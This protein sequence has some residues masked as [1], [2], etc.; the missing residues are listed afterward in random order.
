MNEIMREQV[1][2][3]VKAMPAERP[4]SLY[5][6]SLFLQSRPVFPPGF[7]DVFGPA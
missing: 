1:I 7:V 3:L 2:E 4:G 6:F 5:D